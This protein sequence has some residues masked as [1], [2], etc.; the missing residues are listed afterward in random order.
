LRST[1]K[2]WMPA[3]YRNQRL[4]Y[5]PQKVRQM[6]LAAGF[7]GGKTGFLSLPSGK[8]FK[9]ALMLPS[10][11]TDWMNLGTLM[12]NQMKNAGIDASLDGVSMNA[13][14]SNTATGN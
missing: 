2:S 11:Y 6:L 5:Q 1:W 12:V 9:L 8:P 3:Q 14:S 4:T 13:W 10:Q 7:K